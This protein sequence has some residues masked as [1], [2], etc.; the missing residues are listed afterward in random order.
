[1][2]FCTGEILVDMIAS[3][4][5]E[6][7]AYA[8]YAGGA[9]FNVACAVQKCGGKSGFYGRVGKDTLGVFLREFAESKSLEETL[10][11]LDGERNTTI[12]F[13]DLDDAGERSFSFYRKG[14]ADYRLQIQSVIPFI[15]K[16]TIVHLG[17]LV[18]SEKEGRAYADELVAQTHKRGKL[19]SF[20]VNYRDDVFASEAEAVAVYKTYMEKADIIKLSENEIDLFSSADTLLAKLKEIAKK[21]QLVVVT[22]GG[23]GSAYFYNG[24]FA[25]VPSISVKPIDTTGAGDAFYGALLSRLD[26]QGFVDLQ[27]ALRFANIVGAL[28]TTA[29]GAI[30]AIPSLE[31]VKKYL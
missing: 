29:K 7:T 8:R 28:T 5:G 2:I 13:V 11:E 20:D 26:G 27:N 10:I 1:M 16:S 19:F 14:T 24:E 4:N 18:I 9:P 30:D 12:A 21:N 3:K 25:V 15:E 31:I 23:K 17:S 6:T 22:L